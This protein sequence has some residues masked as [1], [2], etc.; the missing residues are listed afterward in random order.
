V[1]SNLK[2]E[3][4]LDLLASSQ[5]SPTSMDDESIEESKNR[6]LPILRE[7]C[8]ETS[9][10]G[11]FH[12]FS[13]LV[14][15]TRSDGE[16]VPVSKRIGRVNE[17]LSL[18][19][20]DAEIRLPFQESFQAM[21]G[22]TQ[23]VTL[24]AEAGL[25]PR[26]SLWSELARR[27]VEA[28]LPSKREDTDLS[29][30][31]LLLHPDDRHISGFLQW[32]EELFRRTVRVLSPDGNPPVWNRQK[33][34]L[35]QAIVLVA[36][37]VAGVGLSP[38]CRMRCHPYPVEDSPFYR[39]QLLVGE[40][41]RSRSA[42]ETQVLLESLQKETI[43]CRAELE[44]MHERME[45]TGVSTALEFDMFTIERGL[46]R[47]ISIAHVLFSQSVDS[48]QAVK[49][50]LDDVLRARFEDLSFSAL[51]RENAGLL[52]RKIVERTGKTGEHY[53]A[54]TRMEYWD[55][56]K[57]ALGG[58]L[59]TVATA[60]IKL[61]ITSMG[62]P[63]FF[64]GLL[65]GTDY[66]ISFLILQALGLAL[67]TKQP[68]M[69]AATYAKIVRT[70][71]GSERWEKL[72]EFISRITRTQ[73]AAALGNLLTVTVGGIAF[74]RL[75]QY[76]FSAPY[77]PL[78]TSQYVYRT[79]DPLAS[80]TGFYAALTGVILWISAL[81][82]G[83]A[84]NFATYNRVPEAIADHP[85][86]LRVGFDKM[87]RVANTF[88]KNISGW[89]AS[90]VLGY[91]LGFIPAL[92]HFFGVPLEVR[93]VTLST[94]TLALAATSLGSD[95]L[96]RNWFFY[97]VL[98]IAAIFVLNLGVSFGIASWVAM[99]AYDVPYRDQLQLLRYVIKSFL[100]SPRSFLFPPR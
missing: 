26:E 60:A 79:L 37:H 95:W 74:A 50:L 34:D 72:T 3:K 94:G 81:A 80:G 1:G 85:L 13:R 49:K 67:A 21:L 23:A 5:H 7:F 65:A 12:S 51:I 41:V 92:G 28:I 6:L 57:A 58:G 8:V 27:V 15:W 52:A 54:N 43:R 18:L 83:W 14:S 22:Q 39:V 33:E 86:G 68:S 30:L 61:K 42:P 19:E 96:F 2:R 48:Y 38:E 56:W 93:H 20:G 100:R 98:G 35:R 78:Q 55:M 97:T 29:K 16:S 24:F 31:F 62:L 99:R 44:Y 90:I 75:W 71:E 59:L 53:I 70:T 87:R 89:S 66:A 82:G 25:H 9:L 88:G 32:P 40:L 47:L 10:G 63:P 4:A 76:W 84:E 64:E 91:S 69:T 36:T 73:L 46:R 77:I 17:L 11:R 45:E